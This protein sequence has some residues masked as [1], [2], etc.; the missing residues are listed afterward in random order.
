MREANWIRVGLCGVVTGAVCYL[1]NAVSVSVLAMIACCLALTDIGHGESDFS[2]EW[3]VLRAAFLVIVLFHVSAI[4]RL[5]RVFRALRD[6]TADRLALKPL[7]RRGMLRK[8]SPGFVATADR[9]CVRR[10]ADCICLQL[11]AR[12]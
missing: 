7:S 6:R 3:S 8:Q 9:V 5:G 11:G 10:E 4:A 12:S 2:L 1:L